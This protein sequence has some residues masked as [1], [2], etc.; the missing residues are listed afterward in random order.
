IGIAP[1]DRSGRRLLATEMGGSPRARA[2]AIIMT[3]LRPHAKGCTGSRRVSLTHEP[4]T[5]R[6][7]GGMER[8]FRG[9]RAKDKGQKAKGRREPA[10]NHWFR[11][12][13]LC[14][15][16]FVLCPLPAVSVVSR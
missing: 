12:F 9:Q 7:G 2:I 1:C 11:L 14:P 15:L 16:P 5:W 6:M 3:R 4:T 10:N 8:T 13:V